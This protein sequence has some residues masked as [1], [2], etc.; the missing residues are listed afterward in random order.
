M[1]ATVEGR[2]KAQ[3]AAGRPMRE[4]VASKPT[5]EFD[6]KWGNGFIKPDS[7]VRMLARRCGRSV[8]RGRSQASAGA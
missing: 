3:I 5:S 6:E 7:W 1:L 4:I 2:I 8:N